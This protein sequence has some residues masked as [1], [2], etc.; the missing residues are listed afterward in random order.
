MEFTYELISKAKAARSVEELLTLAAENGVSLTREDA[1]TDFAQL[2]QED[3]NEAS[4]RFWQGSVS[5]YGRYAFPESIWKI[6]RVSF[7]FFPLSTR[8][9]PPEEITT[10]SL[11][12]V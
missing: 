5:D 10:D 9:L 7:S 11:H 2:H 6:S 1:E 4:F 8:I 12:F 3:A